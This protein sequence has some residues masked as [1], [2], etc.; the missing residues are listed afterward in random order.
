M[1]AGYRF[2]GTEPTQPERVFLVFQEKTTAPGWENPHNRTLELWVDDTTK[3]EVDRTDYLR[4]AGYVR[5]P[6]M[7][8]ITEWVWATLPPETFT[9]L[10]S[11][12]KV[13]GRLGQR[14]FDLRQ[15]QLE[16]LRELAVRMP[17]AAAGAVAP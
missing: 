4:R 11:A 10:A 15:E 12:K 16:T 9:K 5:G 1:Y 3:I 6:V 13:E 17:V 7:M 8:D 2:A 14:R